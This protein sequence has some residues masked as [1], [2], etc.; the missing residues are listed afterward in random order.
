MACRLMPR[1]AASSGFCPAA[2]MRTPQRPKPQEGKEASRRQRAS[3]P[4]AGAAHSEMRA[5]PGSAI[6]QLAMPSGTAP[7]T[8]AA[9][10]R[11]AR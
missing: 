5:P 9:P 4:P 10:T 6:A 11:R 1:W 8:A 3:S 7:G 2:R